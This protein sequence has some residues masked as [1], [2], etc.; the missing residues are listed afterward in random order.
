M[1]KRS[2]RFKLLLGGIILVLFP[3]LTAGGFTVRKVK[4]ELQVNA[5]EKLLDIATVVAEMTDRVLMEE[6]KL[7]R[8][9]AAGNTTME[10]ATRV[11]AE[12]P[13]TDVAAL[14]RK[15]R[16]ARQEIGENYEAIFVTD[17]QGRIYASS[18][19]GGSYRGVS[20]GDRKYFQQTIATR[21]A[22][23]G[24]P[25]S[26][27]VTK[28][29]AVPVS[30]PIFSPDGDMVG[31]VLL[32]LNSEFF[33]KVTNEIAI[34]KTGYVYILD[35]EGTAIAHRDPAVVRDRANVNELEGME[36]MAARIKQRERGIEMY[37]F[38]G[39]PKTSGFAPMESSGWTVIAVQNTP[40]ILAVSDDILF[41]ILAVAGVFILLA[42]IGVFI[43]S[44]RISR[45]IGDAVNR[46]G[47][48]AEEVTTAAGE[49][50]STSQSL[51][52]GASEQA[53]SLE[54][55]TA[56]LEEMSSM[57]RQ[58]ADNAQE[59]QNSRNIALNSLKSADASMHQA[60]EAMQ[61]I[62]TKG[63]EVSKIVKSIDEIAFQTNLLALNAAVE[64]ARA[65][66]AG[67]GFAVVADEVRNLAMRAADAA[68][69]TQ[70]LIESTITEIRNGAELIEKTQ[71]EFE[72][73]VSNNQKVAELIDEIAA[74]CKE[75]A[76]GIE[77]INKAMA[78]MD[79]V[80]QNNA[81][82]SEE[83][84]AAS[85]EMSAQ[86]E[87]MKQVVWNLQRLVTG[88]ASGDGAFGGEVLHR[89]PME[90]APE[91]PDFEERRS[92]RKPARHRENVVRPD[93]I[94]PFDDEFKDF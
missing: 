41:L 74:S 53:S 37:T 3:L 29:P 60:I 70:D 89:R 55:T 83:A 48:G 77:Q 49:L 67:A 43:F 21:S 76:L 7:A 15:L 25:V 61:L 78:E 9:I 23:V 22:H 44:H 19:T 88:S 92:E 86:A 68:R 1:K 75:Q 6:V 5:R 51:A 52:E 59:M 63:D 91:E 12:G 14:V 69:N 8:E 79:K 84:A 32:V 27:K 13:D 11:A 33:T 81:A 31:T 82:N 42:L 20:I 64:A 66:E 2:L 57:I 93:E 18:D 45:Q 38:R 47:D 58:N 24:T 90:A 65:G 34:G 85:E 87:Q 30:A 4:E 73:T 80:T 62:R 54:E 40:E 26:S 16:R 56:S 10:T 72:T 17:L 71:G 28:K 46:I 50:S 36:G 94:I 35:D 39:A